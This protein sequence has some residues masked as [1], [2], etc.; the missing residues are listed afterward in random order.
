MALLL[1][2][3][4]IASHHQ[5]L[6]VDVADAIHAEPGAGEGGLF[7]GAAAKT[8]S[9]RHL[10]RLGAIPDLE[11]YTLLHR[12]EPYWMKPKAGTRLA[13][14]PPET[15]FV[16]AK[17][18]DGSWLLLVPL[19][20]P[21]FRFSLRGLKDDA[22]ELLAE[23]GDSFAP[24]HG[25][26][27]LYVAT[28]PD[29]F[30]L[31]REGARA[32]ADK[33]GWGRLR[34]DKPLPD[35]VD[36]FGWC[37]WDAFYQEVSGARVREGLERFTEGGVKPRMMILDDG[38]QSAA[39]APT[40]EQRLTSFAANEKFEGG[41]AATVR[42]AKGEFGVTTFLAWHAVSGYWGGVDGARLPGYGVVDQTR[43][44]GEGVLAHAPS[45]NHIWWGNVFGL[46]PAQHIGRFYDDYHRSLAAA[47]VDGVKVDS[48]AVLEGV[49]QHQGG[50]V[51]LTLAYREALEASVAKH[52]GGRLI[53]CMSNAQE[54]FYASRA[55]TLLRTS[56]DFFPSMP[57]THGS[58]LFTNA[59]VGLWFGEFMHPDWD[60]FQSGHAWGAFHAAG[61]AISG[62]P[63]YVSDKPGHHDFALL[64]KLV[65]SDGTVLRC[66]G[67]GL[68]TADTLG[69]DPTS[70]GSLLKIWNRN[71]PAGVVGVYN[72]QYAPGRG[73]ALLRGTVGPADVDG[74]AGAE[75]A[76][77]AHRA[78]SLDVVA[79]S[80]RMAVALPER[81]FE[82]FTMVPV[83]RGFAP[84]GLADKF[85]SAGAI[86]RRGWVDDRRCELELRDGG[87]FL[88]WSRQAPAGVQIDGRPAD[89]H[90]DP[91]S[92]ALRV[93]IA[94]P[95]RHTLRVDQGSP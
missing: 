17:L 15:Q 5:A 82:I 72:A 36:Q 33:L 63:V 47:G 7:L 56:I 77:Y 14:V 27:A 20:G 60:M 19:V 66:D 78:Q 52:F 29:P 58:H 10:F 25:G 57:E 87:D 48:Q 9:S 74:L 68:P 81:G 83:E 55:S 8:S 86:A 41:L 53:N 67:P 90:Y 70:D 38:W 75:V 43:Q 40:G 59:L 69:A 95:G 4:R 61:R 1:G 30:A 73:D 13:D 11:R 22:L 71:G 51:G 2:A 44:F 39:L 85:N 34:R 92:K 32:V 35:F 26:L 37:T 50:R 94:A 84:I 80:A 45:F 16:L 54:T 64:K 89:F 49:A 46:V 79:G 91:A 23:T 31:C 21:A 6:V 3:G 28:G 88:A 24:G 42:M 93:A 18:R 12:Y 76:V 65:C 62:G